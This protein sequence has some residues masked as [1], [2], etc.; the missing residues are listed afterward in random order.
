MRAVWKLIIL[1]FC[2][3]T[4]LAQ[5]SYK[6]IAW[7]P[8]PDA[9]GYEIQVREKSGNIILDKKIDKPFYSIEDLPSGEYQVRTAPLN[10]FKKPAVW[11]V[12]KDLEI[13]VSE[14][15]TVVVEEKEPTIIIPRDKMV[16]GTN[17]NKV[18]DVAI[19]GDNFLEVTEIEIKQKN[20]KLPI[21]Q[22]DVKSEQRIDLKVDTTKA[23]PGDYD[24][25]VTNPYQKPKLVSKFI[26]IEG[27]KQSEPTENKTKTSLPKG[28]TFK[29][30]TY[31]EMM[32]FLESNVAEN[33]KKTQVPAMMLGECNLTYVT[34]NLSSEDNKQVFY[35]YKLISKNESDR[36][37]AYSHF[38]KHCPPKF[39]AAEE[40]MEKV[41]K[42]RGNLSPEERYILSTNLQK[43]R[44]CSE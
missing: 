25:T 26:K 11:S 32:A 19:T 44:T 1:F 9:S 43:L 31:N 33:C 21:L 2:T 39:K 36:T 29:D 30:Y 40:R 35:F 23:K 41:W 20:D 16:G 13:I 6:V 24:L 4:L 15:P 18:T 22:K 17:L 14:P 7:K 42:E 12:W 3:Q 27:D 5:D 10:L 34:L 28:K 8:I 37:T 38:S